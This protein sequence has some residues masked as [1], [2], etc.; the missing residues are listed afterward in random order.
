MIGDE[1]FK[2]TTEIAKT[3]GKAI[4]AGERGGRYL[5]DVFREAIAAYAGAAAD[6]AQG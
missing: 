2:A 5:A 1:G 3:T 4:D 6:S